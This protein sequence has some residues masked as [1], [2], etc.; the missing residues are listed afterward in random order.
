MVST[1]I[2]T[3]TYTN[4]L[5]EMDALVDELHVQL[6]LPLKKFHG[7]R[8]PRRGTYSITV[9]LE[10]AFRDTPPSLRKQVMSRSGHRGLTILE[11][12]ALV[13]KYPEILKEYS[14]DIAHSLYS[15]ECTPTLYEWK[16]V[17]YLSAICP[18]AHE[19]RCVAP[20]VIH[21]EYIVN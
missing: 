13:K 18:D 10:P 20:E 11:A 8:L 5:S 6:R 12:L 17:R 1:S 21:C 3:V 16:G 9:L 7:R 2:F 14:L 4:N 19:Q 15:L